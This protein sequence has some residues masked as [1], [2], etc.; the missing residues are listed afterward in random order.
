MK[1]K[2]TLI[3]SIA[4]TH[5]VFSKDGRKYK[6]WVKVVIRA[7]LREAHR[8]IINQTF[9]PWKKCITVQAN[10]LWYYVIW[11]LFIEID[12]RFYRKQSP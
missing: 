1:K 6:K 8:F 10:N 7:K 3:T 4:Y 2:K 12:V 9:F 11:S 5:K